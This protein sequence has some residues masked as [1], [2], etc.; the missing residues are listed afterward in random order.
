MGGTGGLPASV[1]R[2]LEE[3]WRTSRQWHPKSVGKGLPQMPESP[4]RTSLLVIGRAFSS[5]M[6][7]VERR[8]EELA[9]DAADVRI[10]ANV[11]DALAKSTADGWHAD[12]V[13]VCQHWPD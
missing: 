2:G 5:E 13:G 10:A 4:A 11:P 6:A 8:V 7:G 3:H 9:Q 12:L 1:L